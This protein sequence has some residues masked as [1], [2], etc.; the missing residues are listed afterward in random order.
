MPMATLNMVR[1]DRRQKRALQSQLCRQIR[2]LIISGQL[3]AGVRLPSTRDLV[4]QL[5]VSRNT[6]VYALDQLVAEGYLRTR[7]GSGIYVEDLPGRHERIA[8]SR[9]NDDRLAMSVSERAGQFVE[10]S[11]SPTYS[12]SKVLPFRPCQPALDHF[13][14]RNWNRARSYALR[15]QARQLLSESDPA[16]LPRLRAALATYLR[17]SRGV[18]CAA[19][20]VIV[21]AGAQ[22]GLSLIA[23][24]F[25]SPG[26]PVWIED[27]GY[28]GARAAF[29]RT[30][31][32]LIPV[33]VD[34]EGMRIP[35]DATIK[36]PRLIYTTPSRQFPLGITMSLSRRLA[37]LEFARNASAWVIEDD[38]DSEFRYADRPLPALQ[39]LSDDCVIYA[40]SFSKVLFPSLRLGYLVVPPQLVEVFH[41]A[42][43]VHDGSTTALDQA[44]AAIFI[45]EGFF[46]T[47]V[48]RMRRLY[49]ERRDIFLQEVDKN[50]SGLI[51]FPKVEAGMDVVGS[52]PK[53]CDDEKVSR[54]LALHHID[55]PPLSAYSLESCPPGLVFGF[56][57]FSGSQVRSAIRSMA[58][59]IGRPG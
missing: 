43:E 32:A 2:E 29:L 34:G 45:E 36:R 56:T 49:R 20:Q 55:A 10:L 5:G 41:K 18:R 4:G 39:G 16:G 51:S 21:T 28:L 13:P 40:G 31:A 6:I 33:P 59:V 44:T 14:I 7:T 9:R 27:P 12:S 46:S 17:E 48:R 11:I 37:L 47:H 3:K 19:D 57:A 1:V 52:L 8:P 23:D 22:Q 24:C 35:S 30:G 25:V 54:R 53:N 26:D 50:L 58:E 38:Y 15:T 42:K